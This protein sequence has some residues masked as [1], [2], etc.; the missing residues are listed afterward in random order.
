MVLWII[1]APSSGKTTLG[2]ELFKLLERRAQNW[3]FFDEGTSARI[4]ANNRVEAGKMEFFSRELALNG[5]NVLV[6]IASVSPEQQKNNRNTIPGYKDI[7]IKR[8]PNGYP[9]DL[10]D[11]ADGAELAN[12]DIVIN[13]KPD[14]VDFTE[15]A[16]EVV[17][18]LGIAL[19]RQYPYSMGNKFR[20]PYK[21]EYTPYDG[22]LLLDAY[23]ESRNSAIQALEQKLQKLA[24][25]LQGRIVQSRF[26]REYGGDMAGIGSFIEMEYS[27]TAEKD[28]CICTVRLFIDLLN[29][30]IN[31]EYTQ[32]DIKLIQV[33]L[34]KFELYK[35]LYSYYDEKTRFKASEDYENH[36]IYILFA[37]ILAQY[38]FSEM[39]AG[40]QTVAF[41]TMLKLNDSIVSVLDY[42]ETPVEIV[43][44]CHALRHEQEVFSRYA[45]GVVK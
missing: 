9:A 15:L 5:N 6:C 24:P 36:M 18:K 19:E 8:N 44:A 38:I 43:L 21:Y 39:D 14:N 45:K 33:F 41:N 12:F 35:R 11:Q 30:L 27:R 7:C 22:S 13:N 34:K 17:V 10:C 42:I 28:G 31:M 29:R 25:Y 26:E 16:L 40:R 1:G 4:F 32:Q 3:V 23:V 37:N 2:R 20:A